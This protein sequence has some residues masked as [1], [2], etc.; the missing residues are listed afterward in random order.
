MQLFEWHKAFFR[1]LSEDDKS[2]AGHIVDQKGFNKNARLAVYQNNFI[3]AAISALQHTYELTN[4]LV[5]EDYFA[6]LGKHFVISNPPNQVDLHQYGEAFPEYLQQLSHE[7]PELQSM[8]Y[9]PDL[10]RLDWLC[11]QI[12]FVADRKPWPAERFNLLSVEEQ[13][14][15]GFLISPDCF[16]QTSCWPL[17]DLW[18]VIKGEKPKADISYGEQ[19]Y[20]LVQRADYQANLQILEQ[21]IYLALSSVDTGML[22][23]E[24]AVQHP[25]V[26]EDLPQWIS[27]GW[28]HEFYLDD[29]CSNVKTCKNSTNTASR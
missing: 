27:N 14:R 22:L 24:L 29:K 11:Y 12:Y 4:T 6:Q 2:L 19:Q 16:L 15:V 8:A 18:Q 17:Y 3:Q 23:S 28:I 1:L 25:T 5:G 9:I 20:F 21:D 10:A 26:I 13:Q 7:R